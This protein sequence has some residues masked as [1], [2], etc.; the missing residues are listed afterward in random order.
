MYTYVKP[1]SASS[2]LDGPG[3]LH[4]PGGKDE[5]AK[6]GRTE[7]KVK[8]TVCRLVVTMQK[9]NNLVM[10]LLTYRHRLFRGQTGFALQ[11]TLVALAS[12][13]ALRVARTAHACW[14]CPR[15]SLPL[16]SNALPRTLP[17]IRAERWNWAK[18]CFRL[19]PG[20]EN[21][22]LSAKIETF[23]IRFFW[24]VESVQS[25]NSWR[26]QD[27]IHSIPFASW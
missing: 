4:D 15:K 2:D 5:G 1:K 3:F 21:A 22:I 12:G 14:K 16:W 20:F 10:Q 9:S 13:C 18:V 8:Y 24:I 7:R 23:T 17:L 19:V 25:G 11:G 6:W 27:P 26:G